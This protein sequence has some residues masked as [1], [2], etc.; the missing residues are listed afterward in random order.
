MRVKFRCIETTGSDGWQAFTF[1]SVHDGTVEA[2]NENTPMTTFSMP[3][4]NRAHFDHFEVGKTYLV[5][6][7]E[8]VETAG[9]RVKLI[10]A[11]VGHV[12][13]PPE[14]PKDEHAGIQEGSAVDEP[15]RAS[16]HG[17]DAGETETDDAG[18]KPASADAKAQGHEKP[19]KVLK[20]H[21]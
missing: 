5:D 18:G 2:W 1:Q 13:N 20:H 7:T 6:F 14:T 19:H 17:A 4:T 12:E 9:G 3:V 8:S 15:P 11:A 21:R 16:E 10:A